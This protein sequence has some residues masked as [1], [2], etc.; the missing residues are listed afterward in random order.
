MRSI[1]YIKLKTRKL[2]KITKKVISGENGRKQKKINV[3]K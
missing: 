1:P 3:K 2:D